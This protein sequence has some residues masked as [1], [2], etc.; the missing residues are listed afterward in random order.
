M[1]PLISLLLCGALPAVVCA[2]DAV[3]LSCATDALHAER[4]AVEPGFDRSFARLEAAVRAQ[5]SGG[6]RV[7]EG[8]LVLP[9][10]VH[11]LHT[12]TP[13]GTG[14]N[15]SA[16]Q[17]ESAIAAVNA[18]LRGLS[19]GLDTEIELALA[20]RTPEGLPTDG[21]VRVDA[22]TVPGYSTDGV[23]SAGPVGAS[24]WAVKALSVWPADAYVN[25]WVVHAINGTSDG[26]GTLGFAYLPP[27]PAAVDGIV[28]RADAFGTAGNLSS[29]SQLNRTLTHELG[30]YLGLH[31]TFHATAACGAESDCTLE[32]DRVCDTPST[33]MNLGCDQPAA[34]PG[35]LQ[36]NY[37]DYVQEGCMQAF[38]AG[39]IDRMRA[40]LET[41][42]TSLTTSL[43][44]TPMFSQDAAATALTFPS[45]ACV[46]GTESGT[47]VVR[48]VGTEPLSVAAVTVSLNGAAP[49]TV[50]VGL[51][52]APNA[53]AEVPLPPLVW[54]AGLNTL[55][56][57]VL[58]EGDAFNAND[59]YILQRHVLP[60]APVTVTV[61]PD[62]F[63]YET[64]WTILDAT[65]AVVLEG[66]PYANGTTNTPVVTDGCVPAGCHTFVMFDSYG[67]GMAMG[68]GSF[69]ATD[70]TGAL[71][72]V[73]G[74][75]FGAA[76]E[77]PFCIAAS[78]GFPCEDANENGVCD[79]SEVA[80]CIDATACDYVP[81]ATLSAPCTYPAPGFDC[82]GNPVVAVAPVSSGIPRALRVH[83]NPST[84][85]T[86]ELS[87]L[88]PRCAYT[89]RL[90]SLDGAAAAPAVEVFTDGT[91]RARAEFNGSVSAGVYLL[92]VMG[93]LRQVQR[94]AIH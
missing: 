41:A 38:T 26:G 40:I 78:P 50:P 86:W 1:K 67:D 56:L 93:G 5:P 44:A 35:A 83:P 30:H 76:F 94:V 14:A 39:Q 24:E 46:S 91:G 58:A 20:R 32:G 4:L 8:V 27:A 45:G 70:A 74:G 84:A 33:L 6:T 22:S 43:G 17:I 85:P 92:E 72:F 42:R 7:T 11:V 18:D 66:G 59:T 55:T 57:T 3:T 89:I 65:G 2:Q 36:N 63:G 10:V 37:M 9:V 19:G 48:N 62:V 15:V 29:F 87:G 53:V 21:I 80:G 88:A 23:A 52:L 77:A 60:G 31:H 68:D 81:E 47:A 71:L 90:R 28:V 54:Q 79:G 69:S 75:N 49:W 34:C 25:V 12:G 13:E 73:G 16:T 61:V 82:A 51:L 64:T